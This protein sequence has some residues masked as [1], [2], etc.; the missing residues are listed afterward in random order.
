MSK[1]KIRNSKSLVEESAYYWDGEPKV[2]KPV[3]KMDPKKP[4]AVDLFC[5]LGGLSLGFEMNGFQVALGLDIHEPSTETFRKSHRKAATIMGDIRDI[6]KIDGNNQ[7]NIISK[8]L[9]EVIGN[10]EVDVLMA[11]IP[12]QGFSLS[13]KKRSTDDER[14]YL[15]LYFMEAAKVIGP[16]YVLIENVS[17]LKSMENGSF[18]KSI[19][20]AIRGCG[21]NV[22]HR[23]LNARDFGVPQSRRRIIFMGAKGS[24]PI[25]WPTPKF[26]T[27]SNPFRTVRDAISDLPSLNSG[28]SSEKYSEI[29]L[30]ELSEYQRFMRGEEIVLK[31][32]SSP[33]HPES[34]IEKIRNT[35]PGKPMYENYKQRIRLTWDMTSPTQVSGGIRSQFQFGH[36]E[37]PRGLTVRERCRIQSIPD[38]V[39]IFGGTVQ[40]RVQT[41][42]AVPCLLAKAL[43]ECIMLGMTDKGPK[44]ETKPRQTSLNEL[45]TLP[46]HD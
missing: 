19:E 9:N 22:D 41:G 28:E 18:V 7:D 17:G 3:E 2:F 15:F 20:S 10:R 12:C 25:I 29:P 26:G 21:Y 5:G 37:Q 16:K 38:W 30:Q 8:T 40:G 43:A 42:N 45:L 35:V 11:G 6:I 31:N 36:P 46:T 14:N 33:K 32:H 39:E 27:K 23:I 44:N 24:C 4:I 1:L 34:T 13:N